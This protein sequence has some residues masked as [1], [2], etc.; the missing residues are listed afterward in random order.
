[1][2][3]QNEYSE[4]GFRNGSFLWARWLPVESIAGS[5]SCRGAKAAAGTK[6]CLA[7]AGSEVYRVAG[8]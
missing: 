3:I 7:W 5:Q 1:M 2:S 6:R 4:R 8:D